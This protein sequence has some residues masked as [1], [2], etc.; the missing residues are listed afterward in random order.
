M[1][2]SDKVA[3]RIKSLAK[4]KNCSVGTLLSECDLSKNALSSMRSGGFFP[5]VETIA[6]IADYLDCSIDYLLGRSEIPD[7]RGRVSPSLSKL[8]DVAND[9]TDKEISKTVEY[10]VLLRD[11]RK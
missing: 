5:R 4:Q 1:Y 11:A 6:R 2:S 7:L 10:A 3:E 9:L 8:I